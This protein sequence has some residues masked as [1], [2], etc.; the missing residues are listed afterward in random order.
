MAATARNKTKRLLNSEEK[1]QKWL[2]E[3]RDLQAKDENGGLGVE[4]KARMTTILNEYKAHTPEHDAAVSEWKMMNDLEDGDLE[5]IV[6]KQISGGGGVGSKANMVFRT[7][8]YKWTTENRKT[9]VITPSN[10]GDARYYT[11]S[12][13]ESVFNEFLRRPQAN[14]D[15]SSLIANSMAHQL[16]DEKIFNVLR[17]DS[18][19]RG[20]NFTL[21]EEMMAGVLKQID[22]E[23]FI[24][25]Y[26]RQLTVETSD[27]LGIRT[28]PQKANF[29]GPGSELSNYLANQET[30]LKFGK[31]VMKTNQF[32][33]ALLM[34]NQ[35]L[36]HA[37]T[38][39]WSLYLDEVGLAGSE[40]MEQKC[41]TGTGVAEPLGVLTV[42][43]AN[44][45]GTDRD[46]VTATGDLGASPPSGWDIQTRFGYPTLLRAYFG[47]KPQHRRNARWMF[48]SN[49]MINL[50]LLKDDGGHYIWQ[51]NA[52]DGEPSLLLGRPVDESLWLSGT[53]AAEAYFG[54]LCNWDYYWTIWHRRMTTRLLTEIL[55]L[56]DMT[57][58]LLGFQFD[59]Q[60]VLPEA[61][62]R[63]QYAEAD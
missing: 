35:L 14:K 40:W 38:D 62:L 44:G 42:D 52:R 25:R 4:D 10:K 28:R 2:A 17:Q 26:S 56:Q 54:L 39:M 49:Q 57:V 47:M 6:D 16:G 33:M 19:A 12:A 31:R 43:S 11:T 27:T 9:R 63:L 1:R 30:Q 60:P 15:V 48:H 46:I 61:F 3:V 13:Y 53:Q 41:L 55:A 22:N 45:L 34:S 50:A 51:P 58:M 37:T 5:K 21:P 8:P 18:D 20:G 32:K 23:T 7:E 36:E 29:V 24:S 59:A